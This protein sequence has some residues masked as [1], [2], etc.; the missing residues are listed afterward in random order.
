[1]V[2]SDLRRNFNPR[3]G[4]IEYELTRKLSSQNWTA[5][6][7][8]FDQ[9][10]IP[11]VSFLWTHNFKGYKRGVPS[12]ILT[13]TNISRK[14]ELCPMAQAKMEGPQLRPTGAIPLEVE[15]RTPSRELLEPT[16]LTRNQAIWSDTIYSEIVLSSTT[17][18]K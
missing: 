1:M 17:T 9:Y 16:L 11:D 14:F 6:L 7:I 12:Y 4:A 18:S 15:S 2:S 13:G 8:L 10:K 5:N 3:D